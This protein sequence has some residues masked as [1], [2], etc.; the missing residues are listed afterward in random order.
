MKKYIA[1]A[2]IIGCIAG[3]AY[4]EDKKIYLADPPK[5]PYEFT[6]PGFINRLC[7]NNKHFSEIKQIVAFDMD[8]D[9]D[10]DLAVGTEYGALIIYENKVPQK[11]KTEYTPTL[12]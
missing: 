10:L 2:G 9:G 7:Y 1:L 8:G 3:T 5:G 11:N 6:E 12:K 4:A